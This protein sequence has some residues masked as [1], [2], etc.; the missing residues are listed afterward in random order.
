MIMNKN[1]TITAF[2]ERTGRTKVE[3]EKILNEITDFVID[4]MADDNGIKLVGFM[5]LGVKTRKGRAGVNPKTQEKITI[6]S[7]KV[8]YAKFGKA[9]KLSAE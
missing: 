7:K 8:P 4:T 1:E 9:L 2:A 3:S 6:P 5:E